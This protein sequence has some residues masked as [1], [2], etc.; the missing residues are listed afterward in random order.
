M[1]KQHQYC[2]KTVI[3][4][5]SGAGKS[6]LLKV[7]CN[8]P[9]PNTH[10]VTIGVDY[11]SLILDEGNKKYKFCLWDTSGNNTFMAIVRS[12]FH[13]SAAAILVFDLNSPDSF[14]N[15]IKWFEHYR[16]ICNQNCVIVVGNKSDLIKPQSNK[17]LETDP[18]Q[19]SYGE[20]GEAT[21]KEFLNKY[22]LPYLEISAKHKK[23]TDKLM[24][25]IITNV[26]LKVAKGEIVPNVNS[27]F[28]LRQVDDLDMA[29]I[30]RSKVK[31]S[32]GC[33]IIS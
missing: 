33:C 19:F 25:M 30:K 5:S 20:I 10:D 26:N 8:E 3:V 6:S 31:E 21:I 28:T 7:L 14:I 15:S 9:F 1:P 27:G 32:L 24:N 22:D 12:Y 29:P 13:H 17:N 23:N 16:K 11:G 4:G 18:N 2:L